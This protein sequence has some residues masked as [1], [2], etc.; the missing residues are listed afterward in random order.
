MMG[1]RLS[2]LVSFEELKL[3]AGLL[4]LAPYVP[5]LFMG[6]EYAETAPF[7]YFVSH[8][9][10]GLVEAVREGRK[11]EFA[12]FTG[13]GEMPDAQL[14]ATFDLCRLNLKMRSEGRHS[15]L[16]EWYRRLLKLRRELPCLASLNR[17]TTAV[18]VTGSRH[19]ITLR[20]WSRHEEIL[21]VFHLGAGD[22]AVSIPAQ[23]DT[24]DLL[25]DS[26]A[27]AFGGRGSRIPQRVTASGGNLSLHLNPK[28]CA[29]LRC[30][31]AEAS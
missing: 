30:A 13:S 10:P 15:L 19:T 14:E 2:H 6:Q 20:R 17:Q 21:A 22:E 18:D 1:E 4:L 16:L 27:E 5:L 26:A 8:S 25:L 7:L 3:A 31:S 29:L 28:H 12:S 23:Y 9:D 24:W 11:R